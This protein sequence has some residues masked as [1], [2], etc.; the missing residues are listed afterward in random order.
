MA[1]LRLTGLRTDTLAG[2]LGALGLFRA[3]SEQKDRNS[4]VWFEEGVP[5]LSV[6]SVDDISSLID[7]VMTEW[8]PLP[9]A[10]PWNRGS[11]FY[12]SST[13]GDCTD[14]VKREGPEMIEATHD[15]RLSSYRTHLS[16][17]REALDSYQDVQQGP[18]KER[19]TEFIRHL[20]ARASDEAIR[21]IDAA[22]VLAPPGGEGGGKDEMAACQPLLGTGGND[23]KWDFVNNFMLTLCSL[24]PFHGNLAVQEKD[25]AAKLEALLTGAAVADLTGGTTGFF[26]PSGVGGLNAGQGFEAKRPSNPWTLIW[27]LEGA[28]LFGG[29]AT[30]RLGSHGAADAAFPFQASPVAAGHGST[31]RAELGNIRAEVWLPL[32]PEPVS[33]ADVGSLF[34]EARV[35]V[36]RRRSVSGTD[37]A[38]AAASLGVARGVEGMQRVGLVKRNGHNHFGISMGYFS[39]RSSSAVD[40]LR[41]VDGW[42]GQWERIVSTKEAPARF[43]TALSRYETAVLRLTLRPDAGRFTHVVAALGRLERELALVPPEKGPRCL[44]LRGDGWVREVDWAQPEVRLAISLAR[45]SPTSDARKPLRAYLEGFDKPGAPLGKNPI[46]AGAQRM[47]PTELLVELLRRRLLETQASR[48]RATGGWSV[49]RLSDVSAWINGR[50][51]DSLLLDLIWAFACVDEDA[52]VKGTRHMAIPSEEMPADL[53]RVWALI[54]SAF[55]PTGIDR[56]GETFL[57]PQDRRI[58]ETWISGRQQESCE[59]ATRRLRA[60]GLNPLPLSESRVADRLSI[61]RAVGA[62]VVPMGPASMRRLHWACVKPTEEEMMKSHEETA[63]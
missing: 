48:Q 31:G 30:R 17:I 2:Y 46:I 21:W 18:A 55:P 5:V 39:V 52:L 53:P 19:K 38:R 51:D 34:S 6:P 63:Q 15:G 14:K 42:I 45:L 20:R 40:L 57:V 33:L 56:D 35:Q 24:V 37:Y 10:S 1:E 8:R 47:G 25:S 49:A 28:V 27:A 12:G 22:Y 60:S 41:G 43:G 61:R 54:K 4:T 3:V 23:A 50:L 7:W 59:I 26:D 32:W 13:K 9:I 44:S 11:G 29:A 58:I 36:G 16:L 62:L